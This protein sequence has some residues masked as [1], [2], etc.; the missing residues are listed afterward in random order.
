MSSKILVIE[1]E[2]LI[3]KSVTETLRY[4]GYQVISAATGN[5][6]LNKALYDNPDLILC[7][8]MLPDM[9]GYAILKEFKESE[10]SF[11]TPFIFMTALAD[12]SNFRTGME[13]G[14]DDY[15]TKPFTIK[16]LLNAISSRLNK[17]EIQHQQ[18][19]NTIAQI[20]QEL[21]NKLSGLKSNETHLLS[22]LQ[23]ENSAL[24]ETVKEQ[25]AS[26][27]EET[28]KVIETSKKLK[29]A[30][31]YIKREL[32]NPQNNKNSIEHLEKL[33]SKI[34]NKSSYRKNLSIFQLKF[35]M[36]F[37][38]FNANFSEK[39]PNLTM[40]DQ[41]IVSAILMNLESNQIAEMLNISD[42]SL[43]KNRYRLKKKLGLNRNDNLYDYIKKFKM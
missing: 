18:I 40:N 37:P 12:R 32:N 23:S 43:R 27:M 5:N 35:N 8:I 13:L 38:K 19:S 3:R 25:E 20:E 42:A 7:D 39:H 34:D 10:N 31:D 1:D 21:E 11:K 14:A 33:L 4:E 6:G 17:F 36:A 29:I 9:D 30:K 24:K 41:I 15:L 22:S 26:F 16:E 2:E 28:L